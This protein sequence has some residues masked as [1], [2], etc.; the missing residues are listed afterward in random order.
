MNKRELEY[1]RECVTKYISIEVLIQQSNK[2]IETVVEQIKELK[3][4]KDE[5]KREICDF[6]ESYEIDICNIPKE[7]VIVK[8]GD[9]PAPL[10]ALKFTKSVVSMPLTQ[11]RFKEGLQ[12]FYD[13]KLDQSETFKS[14][15]SE[16]KTEFM[17]NYIKSCT[18]RKEV[19]VLRKVNQVNMD[20][21][22]EI[23]DVLC[24]K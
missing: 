15:K 8:P 16:E 4:Q 2:K 17:F 19:N 1:F 14:L 11:G 5:I 22:S 18:P 24:M 12:K 20:I 21:V 9:K 7:D 10:K 13:N 6:M 3:Q 23:H